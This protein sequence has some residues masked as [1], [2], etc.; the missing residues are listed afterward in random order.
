[1]PADK[2]AAV[3]G[4]DFG[5]STTLVATGAGLRRDVVPIGSTQRWMPSLA[6]L[7]PEGLVVGERVDGVAASAVIR[8]IKTAI[9]KN[10]EHATVTTPS[11]VVD[12][13]A[14]DVI[15]AILTEMA[16]RATGAGLRV[17]D[18]HTVR[19]G[20]PAM[21][22][23]DQ[24]RRL[25][26]LAQRAGIEVAD[27]TL[28]DEPIAAGIAW[29]A[30]RTLTHREHLEGR[31][32]VFDMGG[33]T[34]DIAVL[35]VHARAGDIPEISVLSAL[36]VD[37]AGDFLDNRIADELTTRWQ[38]LGID[39]DQEDNPRTARALVR[40][41]AREA[42]V[43]LS[44]AL[45]YTVVMPA[46]YAH[47]PHLTY[48]RYQLEDAFRDP[49]VQAEQ[50][51]WASM[52]AA[53]ITHFDSASINSPRAL[54]AL[55]PDQL[56]NDV[57]YVLLAGGMSQVPYVER[58]LGELFP[59][60]Q[61]FRNA[62]VAP[63]EAIVV[64]LA[65]TSSYERL[66]LHRPGFSFVLEWG[67]GERRREVLYDAYTPFYSPADALRKDRLVY[68]RRGL[69]LRLPQSGSG[70][71]R[72]VT[73]SGETIRLKIEHDDYVDG[74]PVR[75]GLNE[76]MFSVYPDGRLLV[77]DGI[78]R[79]SQLMVDKWPVIRGRDH[80]TLVLRKAKPADEGPATPWYWDKGYP[81]PPRRR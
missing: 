39:L 15:A 10:R 52:R 62:G 19:L 26:R 61:V 33:G 1:V 31:L 22:T 29:V 41:A 80:A 75:F 47:F 23:G 37:R 8:S 63:E 35:D 11:G 81:E 69:D 16:G 5:T 50:M 73:E 6:A 57:G 30:D 54:R 17:D 4:I 65:D 42:K 59:K 2:H 68:Q 78:N 51:I 18:P 48:D 38:E 28:I 79:Q 46:Q 12:L 56:A 21:W 44:Q 7:V 60:A 25:L 66:N 76:F 70:R 64:G 67:E 77:R 55:D 36:G 58:R 53:R 34:L 3:V 32:L 13:N 49:M 24:R 20:C 14:D 9:T 74:L 27:S 45:R 71:I 72:A 43:A 40:R